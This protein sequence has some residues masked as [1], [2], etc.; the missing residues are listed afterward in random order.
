VRFV[1]FG[2]ANA[3]LAEIIGILRPLETGHQS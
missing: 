2:Q 1:P 3:G